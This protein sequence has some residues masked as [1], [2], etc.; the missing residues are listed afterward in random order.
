M[1]IMLIICIRIQRRSSL[2]KKCLLVNFL[3]ND[4]K[5]DEDC[6]YCKYDVDCK[7]FTF[8]VSISRRAREATEGLTALGHHFVPSTVDTVEAGPGL[9]N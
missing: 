1:L 7:Y 3:H 2:A 6:R 8:D 5:K 4:F 9:V